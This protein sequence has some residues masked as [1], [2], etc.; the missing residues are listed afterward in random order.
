MKQSYYPPTPSGSRDVVGGVADGHH[1]TLRQSFIKPERSSAPRGSPK[2]R[3]RGTFMSRVFATAVLRGP[4]HVIEEASPLLLQL[5]DRPIIG[6]PLAEAFPEDEYAAVI[7]LCDW[8]AITGNTAKVRYPGIGTDGVLTV[9][10]S[11]TGLRASWS[12]HLVAGQRAPLD[13]VAS[14]VARRL[15]PQDREP[16]PTG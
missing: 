4:A 5:A 2:S 1:L 6:I 14:A 13:E 15:A 12:G 7:D 9:E 16:V 8:V 11:A 10:R 3:R